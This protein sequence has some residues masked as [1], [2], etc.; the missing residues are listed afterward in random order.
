[1]QP[2]GPG[3]EDPPEGKRQNPEEE[4]GA[5]AGPASDTAAVGADAAGDVAGSSNCDLGCDGCDGPDCGCDFLLFLRLSTVLLVIAAVLPAVGA[6][7][8]VAALIRGYQHRLSRFT[9]ACPGTVSCSEFALAAVHRLGAR[10]GLAE[11]AHRIE[12]CG[13]G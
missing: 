4:E 11:A 12:R 10:R 1:M 8:M 3:A 7:R 13:S 5:W 6:D 2:S 9:P